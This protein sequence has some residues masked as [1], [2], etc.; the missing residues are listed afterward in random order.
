LE[1]PPE[2]IAV[3]WRRI[4]VAVFR[5]LPRTRENCHLVIEAK[6]LD[7]GVEGALEQARRYVETLGMP[8][9]PVVTDGIRYRMY[10]NTR[11]FQPKAYANL[12]RLKAPASRLFELM[13]RP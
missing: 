10:A 11:D 5:Q 6:R 9:D 13:S 2:Q 1:W 4:D 12:A 7:A 3:Q 8:V